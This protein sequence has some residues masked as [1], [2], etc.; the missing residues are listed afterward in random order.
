MARS[1]LRLPR[2]S[3]ALLVLLLP[4]LARSAEHD[5]QLWLGTLLTVP[6]TERFRVR[7]LLQDRIFDDFSEQQQVLVRPSLELTLT[8]GVDAAVG[9]DAHVV[10]NPRSRLEQR[11]WQQLS[12]DRGW[13]SLSGRLRA[14]L[15][16]RLF[17]GSD[18]VGVRA[19]FLIGAR[20]PL[21]DS[22]YATARNEFFVTLKDVSR[23]PDTGYDEN[24]LFGGLGIALAEHM[25]LE[26]GY[27]M[28]WQQRRGRNLVGHTLLF[29][30]SVRTPTLAPGTAR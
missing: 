28:Q 9:Y 1:S 8:P 19:R 18:S 4:E 5:G 7:L 29:G 26:G 2:L 14:R 27:Q 17:E 6:V 23:G 13:R 30:F 16:E 25:R 21:V 10:Q 11:V 20:A 22:L 24:R 15:E 3:L 12:L